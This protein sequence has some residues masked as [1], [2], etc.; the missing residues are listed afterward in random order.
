[1]LHGNG[2]DIIKIDHLKPFLDKLDDP[3]IQK[4]YTQKELALITSRPIPLNTLATRF[5]GKEAVFK[6]LGVDGNAVLLNE[7]EILENEIG[8]PTVTLHGRA[9]HLADQMGITTIC[10]S[11]SYDTDYAIAFAVAE[12]N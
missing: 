1:M 12:R 6:C 10:I 3:F 11:L 4:T 9:K 5:A 8:Q 2:T 7:I